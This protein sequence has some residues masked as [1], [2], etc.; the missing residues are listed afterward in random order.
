MW[1]DDEGADDEEERSA[2]HFFLACWCLPII[3]LEVAALTATDNRSLDLACL[4]RLD[5]RRIDQ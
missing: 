4:L 1:L 2:S 3:D 5:P